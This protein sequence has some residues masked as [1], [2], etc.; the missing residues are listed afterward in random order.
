M[1]ASAEDGCLP[2]WFSKVNE[3]GV[4]TNILLFQSIFFVILAFVFCLMPSIESAYWVLSDLTSQLA[5]LVYVFMFAA[6]I[7]L[8]Y[9]R[10]DILRPYR[11]RGGNAGIWLVGSLG[12]I[13]SFSTLLF[14]F[15]PPKQVPMGSVWLYEGILII[16]GALILIAPH[17]FYRNR[18]SSTAATNKELG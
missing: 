17:L 7:Y 18:K 1:L 15:I 8:R 4:P 11:V 13:A 6:A 5:L 9:K 3:Q 2:Q 10:P 12:I 14:G 16:G